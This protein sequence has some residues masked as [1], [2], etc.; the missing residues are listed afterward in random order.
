M[1]GEKTILICEDC[2]EGIFTAVYDGWKDG[3]GGREVEVRTREPENMELF[4]VYRRILT[5]REKSGKV[6]ITIR[7]KLGVRVYE[8]ICYAAAA[9]S[10]ER[11]TAIYRVLR[12]ALGEGRCNA[13]V[14]DALADPYVSTV[15]RLRIR[16]WHEFHR[17]FGFLRFQELADSILFGKI[18]PDNDILEML[19]PHF[20]NRFPNENWMI[21]DE[22]RE[23]VL[24][25]PKGG[26]CTLQRNVKLNRQYGEALDRPEEY[27]ALWKAF[28]KSITIE[29]RH[30]SGL[31][32]QL[33]PLK[34]R[35]NM[36]EFH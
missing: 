2:M 10:P 17:Y 29:E 4:A 8:D 1:N 18:A 21:Y 12:M 3:N 22:K 14:M 34:F 31:Q 13:R 15:S 23:K 5:D 11:G 35:P 9:D 26:C 30:N 16:V 28:C 20:S 19:G 32:Q 24:V 27:E 25:H 33:L 7:K 36:V 6:M